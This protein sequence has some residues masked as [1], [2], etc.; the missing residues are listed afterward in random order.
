MSHRPLPEEP[1]TKAFDL[2]ASVAAFARKH[3]IGPQV[4]I[5]SM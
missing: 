2:L 1:T 4:S 3:A 5:Q